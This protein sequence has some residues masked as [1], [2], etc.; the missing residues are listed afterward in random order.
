MSKPKMT[1]TPAENTESWKSK[2]KNATEK[3]KRGIQA[4]AVHPGEEAAKNIDKMRQNFNNAIDSGKTEKALRGYSKADWQKMAVE[5]GAGRIAAGVEGASDKMQTFFSW[6]EGAMN[7]IMAQVHQMP[8][9]TLDNNI[10]RMTTMVR[11]MAA[12]KYK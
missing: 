12:K 4:T 7:P 5:K 2:T 6:L 1:M 11:G 9:L 10:E 8:S 3:Y